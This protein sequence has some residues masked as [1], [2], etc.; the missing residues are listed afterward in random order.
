MQRIC[1]KRGIRLET[2]SEK[3]GPLGIVQEIRIWQYN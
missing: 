1:V 2:K 3:G